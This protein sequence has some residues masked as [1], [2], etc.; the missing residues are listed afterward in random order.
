MPKGIPKNPEE[1][2]IKRVASLKKYWEKPES[3]AKHRASTKIG[4]NQLEKRAEHSALMQGD[5]NPAKRSEVRAKISASKKGKKHSD[6]TIQKMKHPKTEEHIANLKIAA[7]RPEVKAKRR[8]SA[9]ITNALPEVKAQR[10]AST[11]KCWEE[12]PE[13]KEKQSLAMAGDGNP[14]KRSEVRVKS[15]ESVKKCWQVP[16]YV[17]KQMKARGVKPNQIEKQLDKLLQELLLNEYKF[18]GDGQ[19]ILAGKCPD[20]VNVNGQKK[21]IELY[22][23]YWHGE[24]RTGRTKEEEEQQRID[25]FAQRGYRTLIIWQHELKNLDLVKQRILEF[26]KVL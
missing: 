13:R 16:D 20:F 25:C 4:N 7:N 26:N 10:S 1:A 11:K 3:H 9:K 8:S 6:E 24:E 19:F 18:V 12:H 17:S 2:R 21:I 14:A 15:S 23:D 22:G 5:N